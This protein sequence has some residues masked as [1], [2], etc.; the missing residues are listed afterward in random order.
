MTYD[1]VRCSENQWYSS[2]VMERL[3]RHHFQ[4]HPETDFVEVYEHG[5]WFLGYRRPN[6]NG[7][8]TIWSTA[9]D[10][11]VLSHPQPQPSAHSGR[12]FSYPEIQ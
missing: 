6:A 7:E 9:N 3:A 11:A 1:T 2:G 8:M 5:G 12:T 4:Q 10:Q